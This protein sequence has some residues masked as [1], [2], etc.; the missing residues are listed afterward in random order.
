MLTL[1]TRISLIALVGLSLV[2]TGACCKNCEVPSK[3]KDVVMKAAEA[4]NNYDYDA[5][6]E[7]FAKD[8]KRHCQATPDVTVESLEDFKNLVRKWESEFPDAKMIDTVLVAE[9]DKVAI[10]TVWTAT[11]GDKKISI[12]CGGV[13]RIADGKIAET[14]VTWDNVAWMTQMGQFPPKEEAPAE[15]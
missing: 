13:H 11:A 8:F 15:E 14:W 7:L 4:L 1:R 2:L 3:N 6:D 5:L 12:D 9:G 10:W